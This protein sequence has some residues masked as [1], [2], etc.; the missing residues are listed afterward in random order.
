MV[1]IKRG[2]HSLRVTRGA[3]LHLYK[4]MGYTI[5]GTEEDLTVP[6]AP[7]GEITLPEDDGVSEDDSESG[8]DEVTDDDTEEDEDEEDELEEKPIS[9]MN[10][11]ELKE[12]A[13]RLGINTNGMSSKKDIRTAILEAEEDD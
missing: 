7:G 8:E 4:G 9:E 1:T 12:Y 3:F 10:F 2:E 11:K 6:S 5:V 13:A